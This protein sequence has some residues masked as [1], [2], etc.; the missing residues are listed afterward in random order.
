[1]GRKFYDNTASTENTEAN[2]I[3]PVVETTSPEP[4]AEPIMEAPAAPVK[5]VVTKESKTEK[6]NKNK[7]VTC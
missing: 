1:M 4:A 5:T 7:T 2:V 6:K 3:E